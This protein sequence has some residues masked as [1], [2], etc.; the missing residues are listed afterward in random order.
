MNNSVINP[1]VAT[2]TSDVIKAA[3]DRLEFINTKFDKV[4]INGIESNTPF[5]NAYRHL[6]TFIETGGNIQPHMNALN[7]TYGYNMNDFKTDIEN[8][9]FDWKDI[10]SNKTYYPIMG[11][12]RPNDVVKGTQFFDESINKMIMFNGT[13]W[14]DMN[15][16]VS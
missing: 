5:E 16:E 15:G 9:N 6:I 13:E 1:K 10:S 12:V 2:E 3:A 11:T 8:Y 4:S 14:V 7:N